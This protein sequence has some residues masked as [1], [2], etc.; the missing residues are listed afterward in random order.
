MINYFSNLYYFGWY[1]F[2]NLNLFMLYSYRHAELILG[3]FTE[4]LAESCALINNFV[5]EKDDFEEIFLDLT[6]L[7]DIAAMSS[8]ERRSANYIYIYQ[9]NNSILF[10]LD[11]IG[12]IYMT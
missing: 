7:I 4:S 2:W 3:K 12:N 9:F 1:Y 11:T 6:F 10:L 8:S 5:E